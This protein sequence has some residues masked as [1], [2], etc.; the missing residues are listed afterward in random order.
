VFELKVMLEFPAGHHLRGYPG[1]CS[2]PHGHNWKMEVFVQ[3]AKLDTVGMAI[4]FRDLKA[5]TKEMLTR[6]DHQDLNGLEEFKQINP[7]AENLAR[8]AFEELG[9]RLATKFQVTE[10]RISRVTIWENDRCSAS[11]FASPQQ[12]G[13]RG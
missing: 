12:E 3:A 1:D 13:K 9:K 7:T 6:W 5:A 11:Y 10:A 4:D 2:R 8:L